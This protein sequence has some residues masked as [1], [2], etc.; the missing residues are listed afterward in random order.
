[1]YRE[2]AYPIHSRFESRLSPGQQVP[3]SIDGV[4]RREK[5]LRREYRTNQE[6]ASFEP[7]KHD[8]GECFLTVTAEQCKEAVKGVVPANTKNTNEWAMRNLATWMTERN[9]S[10]PDDPVPNDLLTCSG[11]GYKCLMQVAVLL[12]AGDAKRKRRLLSSKHTS[13]TSSSVPV[14]LS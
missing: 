2:L 9:R 4:F 5:A 10:H 6:A 11:K 1:M 14:Y 13:S 3:N 12:C 7:S 8:R